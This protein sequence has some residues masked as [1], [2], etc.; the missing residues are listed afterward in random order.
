MERCVQDAFIRQKQSELFTDDFG[1][2]D[3]KI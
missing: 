2:R 1:I 3:T